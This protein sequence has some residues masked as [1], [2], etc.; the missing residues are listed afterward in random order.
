MQYR[1]H[2]QMTVR[3][4]QL[5][6]YSAGPSPVSQDPERC[7]PDHSFASPAAPGLPPLFPGSHPSEPFPNPLLQGTTV[8]LS[9]TYVGV[10]LTVGV[11]VTLTT[12]SQ[13]V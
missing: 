13:V 8:G 12:C 10:G 11:C 4:R 9:L 6:R 5:I 1:F 3:S 2:G 7:Q